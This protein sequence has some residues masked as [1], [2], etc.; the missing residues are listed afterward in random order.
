LPEEVSLGAAEDELP[1]GAAEEVSL[2]AAE[3]VSLGA[4]G[5]MLSKGRIWIVRLSGMNGRPSMPGLGSPP[6]SSQSSTQVQTPEISMYL[7]CDARVG[8]VL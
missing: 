6:V 1:L 7:E 4:L 8:A 5:A 3:E 2:G